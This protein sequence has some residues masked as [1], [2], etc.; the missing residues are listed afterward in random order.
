VIDF[1]YKRKCNH[2]ENILVRLGMPTSVSC[3]IFKTLLFILFPISIDVL[4][5]GTPCIY[6]NR[7][8]RICFSSSKLTNKKNPFLKTL[9]YLF[10]LIFHRQ[11]FQ[12]QPLF[13]QTHTEQDIVSKFNRFPSV[14]ESSK[15]PV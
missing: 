6:S 7:S 4:R 10:L 1:R 9:R 8:A 15:H 11:A 3:Q 2:L 5:R 12:C 14:L 13:K